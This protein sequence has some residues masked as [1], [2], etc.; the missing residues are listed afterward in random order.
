MSVTQKL[1]DNHK[2]L[3]EAATKHKLTTE[4]CQGTLAD[5]TLYIYLAQDL[6]FFSTGLRLISK[7]TSLAP[8]EHSLITLA[9]KIGFFANDENT[10]FQDCLKHLDGEISDSTSLQKYSKESLLSVSKYIDYLKSMT[11]IDSYPKLITLVYTMELVYLQWA[12]DALND[13]TVP[14]GLHWRYKTWIDLHSGE[15]FEEWVEFLAEEVNKCSYDEVHEVFK[16]VLQLEYEFFE[17]CYVE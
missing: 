16:D 2:E 17:S 8:E 15:H 1:L 6:Q 9:K 10:Y 12:I 14:K 11:N 3:F 13:N 7:T 4:L 5:R